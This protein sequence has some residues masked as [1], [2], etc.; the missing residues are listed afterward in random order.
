MLTPEQWR[1][2]LSRE[3]SY[4]QT[5]ITRRRNY[6]DGDH[7]FPTAP[8]NASD[9][10]KRL[11]VLG[12]ANLCANVVDAVVDRS[13]VRGITLN[14][15]DRDADD[16]VW[17]QFW[18]G[19]NL[20]SQAPMAFEESAKTGWSYLMV[21]PQGD[22]VAPLVTPEDPSEVIIAYEAG[23]RRSRVAALKQWRDGDTDFAILQLPATIHYWMRG[24]SQWVDWDGPN[25]G[26]PTQKNTL[27]EVG[28]IELPS[29]PKLDGTPKPELSKSVRNAQDRINKQMF[30][31]LVIGEAQSFPQRVAIGIEI[32]TDAD[33]EEVNPLKSGPDR[34]WTLNADEEGD[35]KAQVFQLDAANLVQVKD[36]VE[37]YIRL[38]AGQSKTP[39]YELA[40]ALVNIGENT[41]HAFTSGHIKK[42]R[43]HLRVW[44]EAIEEAVRLWLRAIDSDI[45]AS[46]AEVKWLDPELRTLAE[47]A[48]AATKLSSIGWSF[49]DIAELL[50][51][52][53]ARIE[54]MVANR[55]EESLN[56][57]ALTPA[58]S[59]EADGSAA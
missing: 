3:L 19:N 38:M 58:P 35:G 37:F 7:P 24:S 10:Y 34:V 54:E 36:M 22:G 1:D 27:G 17:R 26:G 44:G 28:V 14:I 11:A 12:E 21:T 56:L 16:M 31:N 13:T 25:G 47:K 30:D 5:E 51:E 55:S 4:R 43:H 2:R 52:T 59:T 50:G 15:G 39:L 23:N 41:V 46:A 42:V 32:P 33:G 53:D 40:G 48:D 20:D 18:Q 8:D 57:L 29:R 6:Y 49:R 45:D 9:E